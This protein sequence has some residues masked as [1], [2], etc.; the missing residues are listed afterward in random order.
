MNLLFVYPYS[1]IDFIYTELI[2]L[3][4]SLVIGFFKKREIHRYY[5][6]SIWIIGILIYTT[7][8]IWGELKVIPAI[9]FGLFM[10]ILLFIPGIIL[11]SQKNK[12]ECAIILPFHILYIYL[13]KH[14]F[15]L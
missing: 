15:L 4:F 6:Y 13:Y 11:G 8:S 2:F 3:F 10:V 14:L 1:G 12:R 7:V 5:L 9:M